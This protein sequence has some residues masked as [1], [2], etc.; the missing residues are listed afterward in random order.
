MTVLT[1]RLNTETGSMLKREGGTI[2][3]A[4]KERFGQS[5]MIRYVSGIDQMIYPIAFIK[6]KIPMAK[7]SIVCSYRL[8]RFH[9]LEAAET[10]AFSALNVPLVTPLFVRFVFLLFRVHNALNHARYNGV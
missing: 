8:C 3:Q 10:Q 7:R 4:E 5:K 6:N 1:N 2:T 9:A